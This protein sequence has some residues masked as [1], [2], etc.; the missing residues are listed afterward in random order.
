MEACS[1]E[2][3]CRICHEEIQESELGV[4]PCKC[5]GSLK[6][7]HIQCLKEWLSLS[8]KTHCDICG[9]PFRFEKKFKKDTPEA[10]SLYYVFLFSIT[11]IV[12][13]IKDSLTV[14]YGIF[15]Y[16]AILML[17]TS[18]AEPLLGQKLGLAFK[19][20]LV[21]A[22]TLSGVLHHQFLKK[23]YSV[24]SRIRVNI[25]PI[26]NLRRIEES[27]SSSVSDT[28][29]EDD[30]MRTVRAADQNRSS[31]VSDALHNLQRI[32]ENR[33]SSVTEALRYHSSDSAESEIY[34]EIG[35]LLVSSI[36][37]S[38]FVEDMKLVFFS[39]LS[40][41]FYPLIRL[42]SNYVLC[43]LVSFFKLKNSFIFKSHLDI[44][45]LDICST[46]I[47]CL[48][49]SSISYLLM[50]R[51]PFLNCRKIFLL[52]KTYI[53]IFVVTA[54]LIISS[55]AFIGYLASGIQFDEI[56]L[57]F[58][59][60]VVF[61]G[62]IGFSITTA[63]HSFKK[64]LA[65]R[66]RP[67]FIL[68]PTRDNKI[69]TL[70]EYG[71]N[72]SL[73][74]QLARILNFLILFIFLP[75]AVVYAN[76]LLLHKLGLTVPTQ[77]NLFGVCALIKA[78]FLLKGAKDQLGKT[79]AGLLVFI[80]KKFSKLFH[81]GNFVFND[82]IKNVSPIFLIWDHNIKYQDPAT[83]TLLSKINKPKDDNTLLSPK[84]CK[85]S[86]NGTTVS[87]YLGKKVNKKI[88]LFYKPRFYSLFLLVS[89]L[90]FFLVLQ[91]CFS[92]CFVSSL[93]ITKALSL[94]SQLELFAFVLLLS[95][96][97]LFVSVFKY[98]FAS[99]SAT[100]MLN[101]LLV[102]IYSNFVFPSLGS[103]FFLFF[104]ADSGFVNFSK[105]FVLL[106]SFSSLISSLFE[107]V[108]L[109]AYS[110]SPFLVFINLSCFCLFKCILFILSL[111]YKRIITFRT[112]AFP[113]ILVLLISIY[114]ARFLRILFS[115]NFI[116]Q[117]RDFF[118]LEDT[119]IMNHND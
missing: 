71:V 24:L 4:H 34:M 9:T 2:I 119:E 23:F 1:N 12:G 31:S 55:G 15:K 18:V 27:R 56:Y 99:F 118:F 57:N 90:S 78:V 14:V 95:N 52:T 85:Y 59:S 72:S 8:K 5:K 53:S 116:S 107:S 61:F 70:M 97:L 73:L 114:T 63:F 35:P 94:P 45:Y 111:I 38:A 115:G 88:S 64:E 66:C 100:K 41:F 89:L 40:S 75:S 33:S 44:F 39:C 93:L 6:Y 7:T 16:T 50:G 58:V 102:F 83:T 110:C 87:K 60:S 91:S 96:L 98:V 109:L 77:G 108:F 10:I 13:Y 42:F 112:L 19:I 76:G 17:H 62:S 117:I 82:P 29:R 20:I 30:P 22:F 47:F 43:N 103:L 92:F 28:S 51:V 104:Y 21:L 79:V 101:H 46:L 11:K 86:I 25:D 113:S 105:I 26:R 69:D 84:T 65:R 67:G 48:F 3:A 106:F 49:V 37:Y 36:S 54:L 80:F 68:F 81:T 74:F 32:D